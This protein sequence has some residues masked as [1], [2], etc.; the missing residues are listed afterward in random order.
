MRKRSFLI[1]SKLVHRWTIYYRRR[2]INLKLI[3]GFNTAM[4]K[5]GIKLWSI[6]F[7]FIIYN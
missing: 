2:N 6:F 7:T 3:L 1:I 5:L 4:T